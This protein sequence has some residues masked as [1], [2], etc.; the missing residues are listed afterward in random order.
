MLQ[1]KAAYL[2][3]IDRYD[4]GRRLWETSGN[5]ATYFNWASGAPAFLLNQNCARMAT[6]GKWD[7]VYC[8]IVLPLI[9]ETISH[10]IICEKLLWH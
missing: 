4:N 5:Y 10:P 2:G 7:D 3:L 1:H 6:N 9:G 8:S